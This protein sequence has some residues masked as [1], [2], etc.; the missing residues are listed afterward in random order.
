MHQN[1]RG[2]VHDLDVMKQKDFELTKKKFETAYFVVKEELPITK[3]KFTKILE[4]HGVALGKAYVNNMSGSMII[5]FNGKW[6]S[7]ELK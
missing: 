5:D 7:N 6:L 4:K 3:I 2:I 1:A